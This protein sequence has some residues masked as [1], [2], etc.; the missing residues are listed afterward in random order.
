VTRS[1][2]E[3]IV[4]WWQ[5]RLGLTHWKLDIEWAPLT[6]D[7]DEKPPHASMWRAR[8]YEEGRL[9]L[10][11]RQT[12]D[13]DRCRANTVV[14]HEL[15]HLVTRE[16]EYVLDLI[17]SHLHRDSQELVERAHRHAVEGAVD[18]IAYRFVEIVD[19]FAELPPARRS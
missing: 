16:T 7:E 3:R 2:M 10:D 5:P 6:E 11:E 12:V 9:T 8:D 4:R 19:R 15:L 18:R 1:E 13:W 17:D 14:V